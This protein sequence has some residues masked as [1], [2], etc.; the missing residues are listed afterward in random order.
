MATNRPELE[1]AG[2]IDRAHSALAELLENFVMRDGSSNHNGA[3]KLQSQQNLDLARRLV[4]GR[5]RGKPG[6]RS[7]PSIGGEA[8]RRGNRAGCPD[9]SD[10]RG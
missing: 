2:L 8:E 6:S 9:C 4:H 1:V 3:S 10:L 7:L 5:Y